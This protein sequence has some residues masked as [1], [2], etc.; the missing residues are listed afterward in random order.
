MAWA[1]EWS[2]TIN[3]EKSSTSLFTLSTKQKAGPIKLGNTTLKNEEEVTYLGVTFDKKQ[4]WRPHIQK[5]ET[6]AR[7]KLAILRKLAGTSWG[8]NQQILKRVYQG[9]IRPHLE[10]GST[11]WCNAA[12]T[13]HQSLD[14]V[15]NQALRIITG[16]MRSTPIKAM[17]E[18]TAIQ[19]LQQRRD[20]KTMVQAEKYKCMPQHPMNKRMQNLTKNRLK[21]SSFIHES[22]RLAR[23]HQAS[24]PPATPLN[25]SD[26]PQPWNED[27]KNL[28]IS[29][30]V[31]QVTSG[32]SQDSLVKR[33]LTLAMIHE[34]YP[35]ESW[36]Y[37]YT[38]GS[39]TSAVSDGGAGV[40]IRTPEGH[41]TTA[42]IPT[43]K[44]CSNY[45]AEVQALMQATTMIQ[46]HQSNYTQV[47]FLTDALSVLE[48][49][50][51]D[52][53]PRLMEKLQ[54]LLESR[55]VVLQWVP[56]HC[57]IPGNER[58]DQLAKTGARGH[59][60]ENSVSFTEKKTLV[61]AKM[62][63]Q[64]TRDPLHFLERQQQV[65]IMRLRTGHCRLNSHLH[66]KM[67]LVP[68]PSCPCGLEDQTPEHVLQT[69]P[70]LK[71]T[72]EDVWP[73]PTPLHTKLHGSRQDLERTATF[74]NEAELTL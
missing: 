47:V 32:D 37:A 61:K 26:L 5:A 2:V 29:T 65:A 19:P 46:D 25:P 39:A 31:P 60:P 53:L 58:A 55:R 69:C 59:Q 3:K 12:K 7:K 62:R 57:G 30:T 54:D 49:L 44:H 64:P 16:S 9:T 51:G 71:G 17:E 13:H 63:T 8:A 15:Q 20:T 11:A 56:A 48:A 66:K 38:D 4:T 6:K 68:S 23:E 18:I 52:K 73:T 34:K 35:A 74:V 72:R 10:Y 33:T 70:L 1:N 67:K 27:F 41:T 28:H 36:I 43:G 45:S 42:G 21:R 22:K 24:I 40:Y 14:K 50:S